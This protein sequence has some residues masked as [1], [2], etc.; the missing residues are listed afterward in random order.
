MG[1]VSE[2]QEIRDTGERQLAPTLE[3]IRADHLERYKFAVSTIQKTFGL[4]DGHNP[5]KIIDAGCGCGYGAA[6]LADAGFDVLAFDRDESAITYAKAH[7]PRDRV[8]HYV[9]ECHDLRVPEEKLDAVICLEVLE[10]L[11]DPRPALEN[12][13]RH[14][15]TLIL[16]VPNEDVFPFGAGILFHHRHYTLEEILQLLDSA[17]YDVAAGDVYGQTLAGVIY[18]GRGGEDF[19]KYNARTIVIV[20]TAR[21]ATAP[22]AGEVA[23]GIPANMPGVTVE[24]NGKQVTAADL[25]GPAQ[26][27]GNEGRKIPEKVLILAMGRS[28]M[29][30]FRLASQ[31]GSAKKMADE[32]WAINAMGGIVAHDRLFQMDDMRL[33][34]ARG[35]INASVA[36]L[37]D[38]LQT[39]PGPVYTSRKY[40]EF[41]GALEFPLEE[42]LNDIGH[43]YFN[44]TVAYA[45]AYAIYLGVKK[46]ALYG[47]DF[48]FPSDAHYS[49]RGRACCEFLLGLAGA[50]KIELEVP[51]DGTLLDAVY[52]P[53]DKFYGYDTENIHKDVVD[54]RII[55]RRTPRENPPTAAEMEKKY[56]HYIGPGK[57][58]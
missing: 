51:A 50:R 38:D 19:N 35:D 6:I 16:S 46:L 44:S 53:S 39:H 11:Q 37:V 21:A 8:Y 58:D 36:A 28:N 43:C 5:I 41:P 42:V 18:K 29:T 10:H 24:K 54:G 45:I 49:E 22:P 20:A 15:K 23:P 17:G 26:K 2:S 48:Q 7:Y 32:I 3:G 56:D 4:R 27:A 52:P 14:A 25:A 55:V 34:A 57:G 13:K 30:F 12:F 40:P 33:Q 1:S 47:C 9:A 31:F